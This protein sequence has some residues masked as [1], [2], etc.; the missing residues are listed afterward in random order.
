MSLFIQIS[1][2]SGQHVIAKDKYSKSDLQPYIDKY[3]ARYLQELLGCELYE[4]F[5]VDFAITGTAPTDPK[6]TAIW[7]A[8][9]K[10]YSCWIRRSEGIKAML[11]GFVYWEYLRDQ[12][13]KNNIGGNQKNI[14][15]NAEAAEPRETN[16]YFNY[17]QAL[18]SYW[19]IQRLICDNP[20]NYDYSTFN[21]QHKEYTGI[22]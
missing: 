22:V 11:V 3:E 6:F 21:G 18:E 19:A 16:V 1:D 8:F 9:C 10:D 17:N 5:K 14:Q 2:F 4:E 7:D 15:A 12:P 13:I 20:D